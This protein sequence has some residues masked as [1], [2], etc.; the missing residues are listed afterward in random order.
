[1]YFY[2]NT[3]D[4]NKEMLFPFLENTSYKEIIEKHLITKMKQLRN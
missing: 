3:E 2:E 4:N 1:M